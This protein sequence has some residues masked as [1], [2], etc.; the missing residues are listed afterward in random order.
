[1]RRSFRKASPICS[2]RLA[3][4]HL[5]VRENASETLSFLTGSL[6]GA[7]L[8]LPSSDDPPSRVAQTA[9]DD[10]RS[11]RQVRPPFGLSSPFAPSAAGGESAADSRREA[12]TEEHFP[13]STATHGDIPFGTFAGTF[14]DWSVGQTSVPKSP[15]LPEPSEHGG[16]GAPPA[17]GASGTSSGAV[18]GGT[19]AAPV[20]AQTSPPPGTQ[21]QAAPSGPAEISTAR[22]MSAS[23]ASGEHGQSTGLTN[24]SMPG[25]EILPNGTGGGTGEDQL[26]LALKSVTYS[27]SSY[28]PVIADPGTPDFPADPPQWLDNNLDG[29][30]NDPGDRAI[31]VAF[32]RNSQMSISATFVSNPASFPTGTGWVRATGPDGLNVPETSFSVTGTSASISATAVAQAFGNAVNYYGDYSLSWEYSSDNRATWT[33]LGSSANEL[34]VTLAQSVTTTYHTLIYLSTVSSVGATTDA[35]VLADTWQQFTGRNVHTRS[36]DQL[37]YYKDWK[38]EGS[39]ADAAKLIEVKDGPCYAWVKFF[40]GSLATHGNGMWSTDNYVLIKPKPINPPG[41]IGPHGFIIENWD[42]REPGRNVDP[43]TKDAYPYYNSLFVDAQGVTQFDPR[44]YDAAT[45][46]WSYKWG[47]NA[48][49]TDSAG[50]YGQGTTNPRSEFTD[51]VVAKIGGRYY[52]PSYGRSF[53]SLPLWENSSVAGFYFAT[54]FNPGTPNSKLAWVF[55]HNPDGL[56]V[57]ETISTFTPPR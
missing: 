1:M 53:D 3:L 57:T 26:P 55:R 14:G 29:D 43:A 13:G 6:L 49:V 8:G 34:F 17:G 42:F 56:D 15:A 22:A 31:P 51:H 7:S 46:E 38:I 39:V 40:L 24:F 18:G 28:F 50:V 25:G 12:L 41:T 20:H 19:S 32:V 16:G 4:E 21:V 11:V 27:G 44:T 47:D 10:D 37:Y 48:D 33:P 2:V 30:T 36:G 52:D 9:L 45:Q 5:E 35:E 23:A 54:Q